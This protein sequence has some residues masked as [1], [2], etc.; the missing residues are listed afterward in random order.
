MYSDCLLQIGNFLKTPRDNG[1][2]KITHHGIGDKDNF[3]FNNEN[4]LITFVS[5]SES[6]KNENNNHYFPQNNPFSQEVA[7]LWD[8]NVNFVGC[9]REDH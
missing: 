5:H 7:L 3:V 8:L 9:Y 1:K 4:Q 6:L 2:S